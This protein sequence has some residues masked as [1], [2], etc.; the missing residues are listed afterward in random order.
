MF[1]FR[2]QTKNS[3]R[4]RVFTINI[5]GVL[6]LSRGFNSFGEL[7][8][9]QTVIGLQNVYSYALTR[10]QSGSITTKTETIVGIPSQ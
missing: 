6:G 8:S 7:D 9:E 1:L 4:H 3:A 10:D 2:G 5:Q